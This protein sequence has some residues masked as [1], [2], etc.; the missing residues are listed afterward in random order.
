M[1][2]APIAPH[3]SSSPPDSSLD[4]FDP[5]VARWFR[6]TYGTPTSAQA[7]AWEAIARGE[8]ILLS[9]PTGSG[10]TLAAFL[11]ALDGLLCGRTEP[12]RTSTLYISPLRALNNDIQ[13]NL[14]AP[15]EQLRLEFSTAGRIPPPIRVATRSSDT[16]PHERARMTRRPPELLITTPESLNILLTSTRGRLLLSTVR[17]VILDEIHAVISTK[18]G[19]HLISAVE[20]LAHLATEVQRI[21][22]S[23]TVR[24]H[25]PVARWVGGFELLKN[26]EYRPRRVSVVE[27]PKTKRYDLTVEVTLPSPA[28]P[29]DDAETTIW[30]ALAERIQDSLS[31]HRATLVFANS[32]RMVEKLARLVNQGREQDAVYAHHG[33]LSRETRQ[34]VEARLKAGEIKG[35]V[36]TSSLELGIDIGTLDE[37]L[38]VQTPPSVAS[39]VQR[40][41]R[42]GHAVGEV[43][44][45]R[46]LPL[47]SRDVL[48]SAVVAAAVEEGAIEP[49]RPVNAPLD[50]LAQILLSMTCGEDW[51]I[52]Q[53]FAVVCTASPYASLSRKQFDLVLDMLSGRYASVRVRE[54]RPLVSVDRVRGTVHARPGAAMLIYAAGGTIPD[55][56]YFRL[57]RADSQALVGELDEEF[58]WERSIGDTFTLGVQSWRI[59]Q[60]THNDVFVLPARSGASLAPFWRAEARDR[61]FELAERIGLFLE[62]AET[63]VNDA[64]WL[65]ALV[66][67]H[68]TT[69]QAAE[70]IAEGLRK[71]RDAMKGVLPH[72]HRVVLEHVE[73]PQGRATERI[74]IL[75][76]TWGGR[77]NRPFALALQ[78]ALRSETGRVAQVSHDDDCVMLTEVGELRAIDLFGLVPCERVTELLQGSLEQT[79]TFG[80]RFREAAGRSLLLP[81]AGFDRRTPL[82]LS[83]LRAKKLLDAV[84]HY[85]DFPIRLEVWRE[86]LQDSFDLDALQRVLQ[87]VRD[88]VIAV[89]EVTRSS[90]SPFAAGVAWKQTNDLMYENDTPETTAA[91][92]MR[93]D[94]VREVALASHLRPR[95]PQALAKELERKLHRTAPGWAPRE[96][97]ELLDHVVERVII[98]TQEWATLLAAIER[99]TL[100]PAQSCS[101][102]LA[103]RLVAVA[104]VPNEPPSFVCAVQDLARIASAL[105]IGLGEPRF[106]DVTQHQ[107]PCSSEVLAAAKK[108]ARASSTDDAGLPCESLILDILRNYGPLEPQRLTSVLGLGAAPWNT[109]LRALVTDQRVVIGELTLDT[110]GLQICD[111]DNLERLLRQQRAG[112]RP[113]FEPLP[114]ARWPEFIAS[115]QGLG[116]S[117]RGIE[118]L[119]A[120]LDRLIALPLSAELW[121]AEVLPARVNDY[122]TAWLD[123]LLAET[124]LGWIGCGAKT[125]AFVTANEREL[126]GPPPRVTAAHKRLLTTLFPST[127]GRFDLATLQQFTSLPGAN[128]QGALWCLAWHG[129][130]ANDAFAAVRHGAITGFR[131][132]TAADGGRGTPS[133]RA[134]FERWKAPG[135]SAGSWFVLPQSAEPADP[136]ERDDLERDR[137]RL[138]LERWGVVFRE[139]LEREAPLMHWSRV[140]RVLRRMELSGEVVAGQFFQGVP[141]LQFA[142]KEALDRLR[143]VPDVDH[144][145][146]LCATDPASPCGLGLD[147]GEELPRRVP[148]NHLVF[149]GERLIV[150]S[151]NRGKRLTVRIAPDHPSIATFLGFLN[152]LL[153]RQARPEK[154]LTVETINGVAAAKSE[155]RSVLETMFLV[156]SIR[157]TLQVMRKY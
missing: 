98:P 38:L 68:N 47:V 121:E 143:Q 6:K 144:R 28:N 66:E 93:P 15:L 100:A 35:I 74:H 54:L 130:V 99:D 19:V 102:D 30:P 134:R 124:T 120:A 138:L 67:K 44:R 55:R 125:L 13:R 41:G 122:Q 106:F 11:W 104:A 94:L 42:A 17:T 69:P 132:A 75:H 16:P 76:T 137:V 115:Q 119:R 154:L 126:A 109:L 5:L 43:S 20:R 3:A 142:S 101:H 147:F 18:R 87:E 123:E 80:A 22:L 152:H 145:F 114:L 53:L 103:D 46:F 31:R 111:T 9:A 2:A 79:G 88:G 89:N 117:G 51:P 83:R 133:R 131:N 64:T 71:Q 32:R 7:A 148:G 140:F 45:A 63:Q 96:S 4:I 110:P 39:T 72:R 146:W 113:A 56:G 60:I 29:A 95:I 118:A 33:S 85:D 90:P 129:L 62:T 49:A 91:K 70:A 40:I 21:A 108:T 141:G 52:D 10:K 48:T 157:G 84:S 97:A 135:S 1:K 65:A 107:L 77:V 73:S 24:P 149:M 150:K 14:L 127:L 116:T 23:A 112:V 58:V 151:E 78:A 153:T 139:L 50:V 57:R 37:V 155:Y 156:V 61:T 36:A 27:A 86:C 128:L 34:L 59:V 12:G 26:G 82:W 81:R 8:H 105:G 92:A 25:E 136:I